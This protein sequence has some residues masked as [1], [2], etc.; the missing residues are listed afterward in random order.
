MGVRG[1]S[2]LGDISIDEV[3]VGELEECHVGISSA[4][5]DGGANPKEGEC[6]GAI[7]CS[8]TVNSFRL[9]LVLNLGNFVLYYLRVV[10]TKLVKYVINRL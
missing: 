10:L 8:C 7:C 1:D 5:K 3:S 6:S 9:R 4:V 2:Y